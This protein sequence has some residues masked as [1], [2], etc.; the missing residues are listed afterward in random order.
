MKTFT[1]YRGS[2]G[3]ADLLTICDDNPLDFG[4]FSHNYTFFKS[5]NR[6]MVSIPV[7]YSTDLFISHNSVNDGLDL[8]RNSVI[9]GEFPFIINRDEDITII[10]HYNGFSEYKGT[11]TNSM[12]GIITLTE[13]KTFLKT[14]SKRRELVINQGNQYM[15]NTY[16]IDEGANEMVDLMDAKV[17]SEKFIRPSENHHNANNWNKISIP[18]M[19]R[20]IMCDVIKGAQMASVKIHCNHPCDPLYD[21]MTL[22]LEMPPKLGGEYQIKCD[23]NDINIDRGLS[24]NSLVA[25]NIKHFHGMFDFIVY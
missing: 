12:Q 24:N 11:V 20:V 13:T 7:T 21:N 9:T 1:L 25:M 8:N 6:F 22:Y 17:V 18:I 16:E 5:N 19:N 15:M 2:C 23:R 14:I 3:E 10:T 4:N